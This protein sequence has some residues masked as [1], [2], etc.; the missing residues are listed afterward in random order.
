MCSVVSSNG[1]FKQARTA[2]RGEQK[3]ERCVGR[4]GT[5]EGRVPFL[6]GWGLHGRLPGG[7][8]L[9]TET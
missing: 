4:G 5:R 7:R 8:N 2:I 6:P 9:E 3:D 1:G